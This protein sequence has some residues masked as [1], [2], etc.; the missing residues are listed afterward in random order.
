M[1]DDDLRPRPEHRFTFGLWTVGNPGRDPFGVPTRAPLDPVEIGRAP[2]GARRL[3]R[4]PTTTTTSCRGTRPP[5]SATASSPASATRSTRTGLKV[6][7]GTTNLFGHPA[8]KDG[9]FTSNDRGVRRAAIGKAHAQHRPR[10]RA[11]RR[12]STSSGAGARAPTRSPRSRS[13][14]ALD[15]FREAIDFLL[16]HVRDAGLRHALRPRAEAQRAARRHPAADGRARPALHHDAGAPRAWSAST[17][18]SPTRRWP[19]SR[20]CTPSPRRCGRASSS[21]STSTPSRSGATTRTSASAPQD[22]VQ[23]LPPRA[24]A[25]GLRL[26]GPA[27]LRRPR[28]PLRGRRGRVGLRAPAACARTCCW[29]ARRAS[30]PSRPPSARRSPRPACPTCRSRPSAPTTRG[31]RRHPGRGVAGLEALA[32]RGYGNERLDQ[33]VVDLLLGA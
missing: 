17:P 31:R 20:R 2:G 22:L 25:G 29:P 14:P 3:R 12:A 27:A 4:L 16:E 28:L 7:M 6:A 13:A 1:S 8:F 11:R 24:P 30:S 32:V 23:S 10:R 9:A 21:T 18:R 33:R 26:R 5:P 15:R 19:G